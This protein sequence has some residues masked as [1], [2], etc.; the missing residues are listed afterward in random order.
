[1]FV[2]LLLENLKGRRRSHLGDNMDLYVKGGK[3]VDWIHVAQGRY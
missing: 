2:V 3:N 1:M